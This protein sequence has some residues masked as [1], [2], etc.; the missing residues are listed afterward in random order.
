MRRI[1]TAICAVTVAIA[2]AVGTAPAADAFGFGG[3][4]HGYG[5]FG[6]FPGDTTIVRP[7][8]SIQAAIDAT[9]T[10]GTVIVKPG[11]YGE[12][13]QITRGV[14]LVG[15]GATLVPPSTPQPANACSS[16]TTSDDGICIAGQFTVDPDT[17]A[18]TVQ[19]YVT[20]VKI[21]GLTVQGFGG[22]GI[23]QYGG[24]GSTFTSVQALNNGEYGI[25]AF[26][27]TGTTESF[28]TATGSGEAG[29]YI[30]D[31]HPANATLFANTSYNNQFGFFVRDAE[32][33]KLLNNLSIGNCV[34]ALFLA[35][36]PGPDGAFTVAGNA[37]KNNTKA[38]PGSDDG[39]PASGIGVAILGAHDVNV[40]WNEIAKNVATGP[41]L[42]SAGVFI[43]SGFGGTAPLNNRVQHNLIVKNSVDVLWDGS[44]T[45]NVLQPNLCQTSQ[46]TG[47]C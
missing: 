16:D 7:G 33:G 20:G 24:S 10:G 26:D 19:Q 41:T 5:H 31:S 21:S 35:D 34:G 45:G 8:Q 37:F 6:G 38:C 42:A 13:L 27:S 28:N 25:A 29:F 12:N 15:F 1:T 3:F 17:G 11:T 36:A 32:H 40:E 14:N 43:V 30:G 23:V 22:T 39:P 18:V 4:G 46:P 2:G 9:K 47:L 44:G